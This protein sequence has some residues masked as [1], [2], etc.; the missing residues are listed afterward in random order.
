MTE[1]DS[2]VVFQPHVRGVPVEYVGSE[3][4]QVQK[5]GRDCAALNAT[6]R[7]ANGK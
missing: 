6:W 7:K 4:L 1:K 5:L 2:V 3:S